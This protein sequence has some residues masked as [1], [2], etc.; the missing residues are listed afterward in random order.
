V[1][2]FNCIVLSCCQ[3]GVI[4]K[5]QT[6]NINT[7]LLF[8]LLC[9]FRAYMLRPRQASSLAREVDPRKGKGLIGIEFC[10]SHFP[11]RRV[12]CCSIINDATL[13]LAVRRRDIFLTFLKYFCFVDE[14]L[15][16]AQLLELSEFLMFSKHSCQIFR[17]ISAWE[18][19]VRSFVGT[20]PTCNLF[21]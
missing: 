12:P 14:S 2:V 20:A 11:F 10:L 19:I 18:N 1:C 15:P 16:S 6:N 13:A 17:Y 4:I 8:S 3:Y 5:Q 9:I 7:A 21:S